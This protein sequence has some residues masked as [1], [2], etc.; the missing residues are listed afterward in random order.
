MEPVGFGNT[1]VSTRYAQNPRS[2]DT[3]EGKVVT[4][5]RERERDDDDYMG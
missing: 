3:G 1:G 4:S 2:A 5:G